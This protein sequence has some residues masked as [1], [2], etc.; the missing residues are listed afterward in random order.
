MSQGFSRKRAAPGAA[1]AGYPQAQQQQPSANVYQPSINQLSDDQFLQWSQSG[2]PP[3]A[4]QEANTYAMNNNSYPAN[5][6]QPPNQLSRRPI[7]Q[8]VTRPRYDSVPPQPWPENAN[9][10]PPSADDAW[11]DD[12]QELEQKAQVAKR[13]AQAKRKQIPP[14][15]QKLN[16]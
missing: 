2:Q 13:D 11:G 3:N 7:N 12:I 10:G 14:F 8:V 9:G 1:P 4:Y 6:Q 15:V 5:G 16:R